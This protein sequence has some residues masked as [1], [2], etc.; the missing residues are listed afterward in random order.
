MPGRSRPTTSCS[1]VLSLHEK[2]EAHKR[3][4]TCATCHTRIDPLGFPL[5]HYDSTGRWREK[6]SDGKAIYDAGTTLD[7]AEIEGAQGLLNYL[8]TKDEQV[9]RTLVDEDARLRAGPDGA[10]FRPA[11]DR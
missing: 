7:Q 10:A 9:R 4:A 5:E 8:Q 1:A 2:L 3:N 11:A 6:Y